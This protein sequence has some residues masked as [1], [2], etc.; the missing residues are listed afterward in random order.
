MEV[1]N[2]KGNNWIARKIG[3]DYI[4]SVK[5]G[6]KVVETLTDFAVSRG[7]ASGQVS[8]VGAVN[9]VTLGFYDMS[10]KD[11]AQKTFNEQMEVANIGGNI[12]L[13]DGKT[14]LHLHITLGRQDYSALAGHLKEATIHGAGEFFVRSYP[15][16]AV[17]IKDE[18]LGINFYDFEK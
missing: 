8:G 12:S 15:V 11:Y 14:L 7:L 10:T 9:S 6:A 3:D 17:K 1:Q 13:V 4:V 16:L 5:N 18:A 2:L